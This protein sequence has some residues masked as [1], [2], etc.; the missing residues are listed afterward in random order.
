MAEPARK[1]SFAPRDLAEDDEE[2]GPGILLQRWVEGPDGR[3]ELIELPL[4]PELFLNPQLE[5][6]WMQGERH[7]DTATDLFR[8]LK[9]HFTSNPDILILFDMKHYL[10]TGLPAP[11]P[12]I[13]ITRGLRKGDRFSFDVET[14]GV[15]PS[16]IIEVVSPLDSRIRR[17]DLRDKVAI[18]QRAGIREY[19]IIDSTLR[20]RRFRL[21]GYR[22]DRTGRYRPIE[23]DAEGRLFSETLGLWFQASP[24]GERVLVFEHPGMRRLLNLEEEK[25]RADREAQARQAAEAEVARLKAEIERLRRGES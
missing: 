17:T 25:E 5:D 7:S 13:S 18:Y 24:D 6:K 14:E 4:T 16:M 1:P 12:D 15:A 22:M 8:L 11:G 19:L 10:S 3:M 20:D 2:H 21:L 9:G 23:P